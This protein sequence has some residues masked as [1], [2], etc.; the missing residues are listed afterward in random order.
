TRLLDKTKRGI[1]KAML[2]LFLASCEEEAVE[3]SPSL[4]LNTTSIAADD[5][6]AEGGSF[7]LKISSSYTLWKIWAKSPVEG[8]EFI[9]DINPSFGGSAGQEN[10]ETEV[11][12]RYK[13]NK[14]NTRN[15]QELY[16][17]AL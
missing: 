6:S 11:E 4:A 13:A 16:L 15:R 7:T 9:T 10:V 14:S 3:N 5:L 1:L 17:Q 12:V 2:L 8:G